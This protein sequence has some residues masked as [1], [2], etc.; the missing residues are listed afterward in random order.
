M[1]MTIGSRVQWNSLNGPK[2]GRIERVEGKQAL[3]RLD[4]GK[5]VIAHET[6]LKKV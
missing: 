4:N 3:V 1:E 6:S 5:C 2:H